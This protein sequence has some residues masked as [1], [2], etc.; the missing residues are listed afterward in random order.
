MGTTLWSDHVSWWVV[1]ET[2]HITAPI[3]VLMRTPDLQK[4]LKT[5]GIEPPKQ[6]VGEREP[7]GH[8]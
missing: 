3:A 7:P 4:L 1:G 5:L 8:S 6:I 2:L